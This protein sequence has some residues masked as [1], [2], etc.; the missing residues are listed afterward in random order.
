MWKAFRDVV[1][2][3]QAPRVKFAVT[4]FE[5]DVKGEWPELPRREHPD[6]PPSPVAKMVDWLRPF[7]AWPDKLAVLYSDRYRSAFILAFLLAA[8][9]GGAA[10]LPVGA[11]LKAHGWA[12]TICIA[13]ELSAILLILGLVFRGRRRRWHERWISYRL[14]AELIRH[15]RLAAPLG[16]GRP[17]PQIPAHWATYGQPAATWMAWYVRAIERALGLPSALVDNTHLN[18]CLAHLRELV[19]GQFRFHEISAKRCERIEKQLH[20]WGVAFLGFTVLCGALHL[21]P[22]L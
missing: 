2:D 6:G 18:A 7:Y 5:E 1:A 16:G 10:L 4:S 14:T 12:E 11:R 15:L 13:F 3:G 8:A 19:D 21:L 22:A 17:F 9:A 20:R